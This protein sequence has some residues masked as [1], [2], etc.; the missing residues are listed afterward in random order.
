MHK[1]IL[2]IGITILFLGLAVAPLT[3]GTFIE[4]S[5]Q[6]ISD[7][8]TLYVGGSGEGN[9]TKIQYAI[10]AA[11]DGDTVFVYDDSSPYYENIVIKKSISLIGE[12]KNTTVIDGKYIDNV[13]EI[14]KDYIWIEDFSIRNSANGTTHL[15]D[16]GIRIFSN[17]NTITNCIFYDNLCGISSQTDYHRSLSNNNTVKYNYIHNNKYGIKSQGKG[18]III[19]N[20]VTKNVLYGIQ[21]SR[22]ENVISGNIV[23]KNGLGH[24][25]N[26]IRVI[27]GEN[28]V[29]EDNLIAINDIGISIEYSYGNKIEKNNIILNK[30]QAE[31]RCYS[32]EENIWDKNYWNRPRIFPKVIFGIGLF[33]FDDWLWPITVPYPDFVI[34]WHPA[35]K[36]YD[37]GV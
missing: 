10:N 6:S 34:D 18:N 1:N 26:G 37:I 3:K 12:D 2:A 19:N 16:S 20:K 7:G 9:Y 5:H 33:D 11:E 17:Y 23:T 13:I 28:N 25:G 8:N 4:E 27:D 35:K 29:V 24:L 15:V 36:P 30:R 31:F 22:S 14:S 21:I 32:K